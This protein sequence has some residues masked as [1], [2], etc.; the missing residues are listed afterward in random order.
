MVNN[1]RYHVNIDN[2]KILLE[3]DQKRLGR[4]GEG[5]VFKIKSPI[6]F[7]D[8]C[9]KIYAEKYIDD[10]E[11]LSKIEFM[12]SHPPIKLKT[13]VSRICWPFA[14]VRDEEKK[15]VGYMMPLAFPDSQELYH[16]TKKDNKKLEED[17]A[18]F[19]DNSQESC[20]LSLKMCV[21]LCSAVHSIHDAKIYT[22]VD[23][24]P[25]NV[26]FTYDGEI[27]IVDCDSIQIS[28]DE[29]GNAH[30]SR[31]KTESYTPPEG[32][33][34]DIK[35]SI[36]KESWDRFSL[37][38]TL[39]EIMFRIHPYVASFK[40]PYHNLNTNVEK[41]QHNL[42][43]HGKGRQYLES[44]PLPH[45]VYENVHKSIKNLFERAFGDQPENRPSAL[46]W[47]KTL[48]SL[49]NKNKHGLAPLQ[50]IQLNEKNTNINPLAQMLKPRAP[51]FSQENF[52]KNALQVRERKR[53][54]LRSYLNVIGFAIICGYL[55]NVQPE[56][57]QGIANIRSKISD[58][59]KTTFLAISHFTGNKNLENVIDIDKECF[60]VNA[61]QANIRSNPSLKSVVIGKVAQNQKICKV[62][63]SQPQTD[64]EGIVWINI[65]APN[66][67][68]GWISNK[69]ISK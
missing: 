66:G 13:D 59:A 55:L 4:G 50:P 54:K 22:F 53:K 30:H 24:K 47:S 57:N 28:K 44:L 16:L 25:N 39:Y 51:S 9:I 5:E 18:K 31:V 34:V 8:F 17:W 35:E 63:G 56:E 20:D 40:E 11:K 21:N 15:F 38:V 36:I 41:I 10:K 37:A 58:K 29:Q 1:L 61:I 12:I 14:V 27:S 19:F 3:L 46:E 45:R 62:K 33:S 64:N 26:M 32:A 7:K 42:F 49:V 43:V 69:I 52:D 48:Y 67:M 68:S 23:F 65:Q 6:S 2:Q 60:N